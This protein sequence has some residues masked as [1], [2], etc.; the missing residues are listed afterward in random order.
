MEEIFGYI[1]SLLFSEEEN[2]FVVA[3]LK[4]PKKSE[5]VVITGVLPGL[6]IG[7]NVRCFGKWKNHPKFGLQFEVSS[8]ESK[9]PTDLEGIQRYLESGMIKGI[10]PSYAK[11]IVKKFGLETL[12]VID[13]KPAKLLTVPGIGEKRVE[14]I[15][16]C[17]EEQRSVRSVM[18]FLR[19]QGVSPSFAQKIYKKY[20]EESIEK[21]RE[22]PYRIAQEIRGIGFKS[23]D[24]IAQN[25]GMP[26]EAPQR[27]QSGIQH[28]LWEMAGEGHS[29]YPRNDLMEE[30]MRILEVS[31][32]EILPQL[33]ALIH[34][35][36]IVEEE[37]YL[38]IKPLYVAEVEIAKELGRIQRGTCALRNVLIEKAIEWVQK[39]LRIEFATQQKEGVAAALQE[40][41]L[42]LTGGP[43]T[44]KSTITNAIL[45][46]SEKLTKKILLAAPTGRAAKRLG[47]ITRRKT[48]TIHSLLEM[49]F[50][51][52]GFKRNRD[53]PL[54]CDLLII[55]EASM[56]DTLL[57]FNLLKAVPSHARI[58]FVG[59]IDQL[60]SVGP[61]N[62][63]RDMIASN[64]L[65]VV[66][67]TEI[68]RQ[69][70][71]SHIITNAHKINHGEFPYL[72]GKRDFRFYEAE[73]PEQIQ[74]IIIR[75]VTEELSGF[76]RMKA[77]QILSPMKRGVIGTENLNQVLQHLLNPSTQPLMRM[78]KRF[79]KGD[80]VMQLRNNYQKE[81]SNG[82]VGYITSI[83]V[84]D[85]VIE[86][87][88]YGKSVSYEF[89]ELDELI[90][91]YAVSIHKYQG[92]ECPCVI[93]PMHT[94][95]FKLL[96]RNLLYTGITRGKKLVIL[97]GSKKAI[98]IA[99]RT[100]E[101]Q[102]RYTG[103]KKKLTERYRLAEPVPGAASLSLFPDLLQ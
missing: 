67:L 7:E 47:E 90:L 58:I 3:K 96:H 32:E 26:K 50:A 64:V 15:V 12:N 28:V 2:G 60:P 33:H 62:V 42:I 79:H 17:W 98:A 16:R 31:R 35:D 89:S 100:E 52:G 92:S 25:L 9:A 65:S 70:K 8:F 10:G 72:Q 94:T 40:K 81:V 61:G 95:H 27:I 53:N 78:G 99:V 74:Q 77:I 1:E 46:I 19:G 59:D 4:Q 5:L 44:G 54:P 43:G 93:L 91:A 86:V 24:Q 55:D 45:R 102:K 75:L 36:L 49:D 34:Q 29:C 97:V 71:G 48:F 37:D 57:M 73:T 68:Y 30:C 56:I 82:D 69:A 14:T 38:F 22:N 84:V 101:A 13:V 76:D 41:I 80:K 88:F 87:D 23:A 51:A 20:G 83:D 85:Q 39:Q 66:R 103:L 21:M 63:L 11:R 18:L 6:H